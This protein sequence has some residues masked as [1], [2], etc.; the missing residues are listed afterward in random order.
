VECRI[1]LPK[2]I[3]ELAIHQHFLLLWDTDVAGG[4]TERKPGTFVP[5]K[6]LPNTIRTWPPGIRPAYRSATEHE[7]VVGAITQRFVDEVEAELDKHPSGLV[8]QLYG[9][10]DPV[11]HNLILLVAKEAEAGGP[12]GRVYAESLT[13]FDGHRVCLRL[14][15]PCALLG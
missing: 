13:L 12:G 11:L 5:Y 6:K 3:P 15:Q 7:I 1:S 10:E 4:Q 8:H 9:A 2:E 14:F